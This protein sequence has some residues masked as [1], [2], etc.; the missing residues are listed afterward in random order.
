MFD[1]AIAHY[2]VLQY[3][4]HTNNSLIYKYSRW[5][6][7]RIFLLWWLFQNWNATLKLDD[8]SRESNNNK[9][10]LVELTPNGLELI[11]VNQ[12]TKKL[13]FAN[14]TKQVFAIVSIQV[15]PI[16]VNEKHFFVTKDQC[17][18]HDERNSS[19]D[20]LILKRWV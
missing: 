16:L 15:H 2:M 12:F 17:C 10:K 18:K 3:F 19:I 7:C 11:D 6:K 14:Q 8:C 20:W 4:D 1:I 13:P 9:L 5:T